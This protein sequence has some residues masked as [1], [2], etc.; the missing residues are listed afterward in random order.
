MGEQ[1]RAQ[2]GTLLTEVQAVASGQVEVAFVDQGYTQGFTGDPRPGRR[3]AGRRARESCPPPLTSAHTRREPEASRACRRIS[4]PHPARD[5]APV[6]RLRNRPG[7]AEFTSR[8]DAAELAKARDAAQRHL[9]PAATA[10]GASRR[11]TPTANGLA[12]GGRPGRAS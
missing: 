11:T 7:L 4:V 9:V 2:V 8:L 3:L 12:Y 10:A 5:P 1:E 6:S